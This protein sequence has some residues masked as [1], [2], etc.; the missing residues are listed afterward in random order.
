MMGGMQKTHAL[1]ITSLVTGIVSVLPSCCCLGFIG[2][3]F[4]IAGLVTGILGMM[5]IKAAPDQ[6]KGGGLAIAGIV[7]AALG[8]VF[9]VLE[10]V[11]GVLQSLQDV[12]GGGAGP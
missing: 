7:C 6:F 4:A 1:A 12:K 5:R 10:L 8:L 9:G 3:P 11:P 2:I